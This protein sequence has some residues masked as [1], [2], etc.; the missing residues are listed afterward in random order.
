MQQCIVFQIQCILEYIIPGKNAEKFFKIEI[1][2]PSNKNFDRSSCYP[3][4]RPIWSSRPI[5]TAQRKHFNLI[6]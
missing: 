3:P 2:H 5:K 1:Y 6:R 4:N